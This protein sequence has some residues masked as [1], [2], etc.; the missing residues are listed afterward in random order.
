[1]NY[2]TKIAEGSPI[3]VQSN[4]SVVEAYL[5]IDD[6]DSFKISIHH[7]SNYF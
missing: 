2:G 3:E 5:G 4:S 1:M 6:E 7:K